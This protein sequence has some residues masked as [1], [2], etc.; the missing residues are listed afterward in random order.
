[1]E[2]KKQKSAISNFGFAII[3]PDALSDA[4]LVTQTLRNPSK[5]RVTILHTEK[6]KLSLHE[7]YLVYQYVDFCLLTIFGGGCDAFSL[8]KGFKIFLNRIF[9]MQ[10]EEVILI[11][12]DNP[13]LS[14][15]LYLK[16]CV[17]PLLSKGTDASGL[18]WNFDCVTSEQAIAF[19]P[20]FTHESWEKIEQKAKR[21]L[22]TYLLNI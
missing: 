19:I 8:E 12:F 21:I 22:R 20:I 11:A 6:R 16:S 7:A 14:S 17:L 13:Q 15:D 1:M 3:F 4:I 5:G 9:R 18:D 2:L 10:H